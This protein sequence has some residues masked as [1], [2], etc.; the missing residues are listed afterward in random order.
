MSSNNKIWR[1]LFDT[2]KLAIRLPEAAAQQEDGITFRS[3][4]FGNVQVKAKPATATGENFMS[5]AYIVSAVQTASGVEHRSFVKVPPF[6]VIHCSRCTSTERCVPGFKY[7]TNVTVCWNGEF[8]FPLAIQQSFVMV[9]N[10]F[11]RFRCCLVHRCC[12][13]EPRRRESIQEK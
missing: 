3:T 4:V 2:E 7:D 1:Y 11:F 13:K 8:K 10:P 5:D 9:V 6:S 12:T